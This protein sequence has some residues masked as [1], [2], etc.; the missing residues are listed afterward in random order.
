MSQSKNSSM[1]DL[2][3][4]VYR[5]VQHV[6][7]LGTFCALRLRIKTELKSRECP[8]DQQVGLAQVLI[9]FLILS[10]VLVCVRF[11]VHYLRVKSVSPRPIG[12]LKLSPAGLQRQMF[13]GLSS[14]CRTPGL[15]NLM[16]DSELLL[17]WENLCNVII[18]HL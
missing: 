5:L 14:W 4:V 15:G 1:L 2:K 17:L 7:S 12:F 10:W 13:R 6:G 9:K 11:C 18:L 16:R 8:Q 3:T